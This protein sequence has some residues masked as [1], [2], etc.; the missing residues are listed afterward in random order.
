MAE[1]TTSS[2]AV[3]A[4][5]GVQPWTTY[6]LAKQME[7][8]LRTVWPRAESVIYE[9]PKKLVASGHATASV[10]HVGRRRSTTYA[11]TQKGRRAL[12]KWLATPGGPPVLEFEAMLKVAFADLGDLDGL[13]RNVA[14][15]ADMAQAQVEYIADRVREYDETGGPFPDRLPVILL[16]AKFHEERANAL[17]RWAHWAGREIAGWDGVTPAT[18]AAVPAR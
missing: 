17:Q 10:D 15:I 14:A 6:Q 13:R 3:L 2:Y 8:S 9:Q 7:R 12:R 5:L 1:L 4:L 11:I 18:G 16:V